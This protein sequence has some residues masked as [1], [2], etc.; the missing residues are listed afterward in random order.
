MPNVWKCRLCGEVFA[1]GVGKKNTG[2]IITHPCDGARVQMTSS[3]TRA[4]LDAAE[5]CGD[6]EWVGWYTRAPATETTDATKPKA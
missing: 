6:A 3:E 1:A 5:F 4:Q 2:D